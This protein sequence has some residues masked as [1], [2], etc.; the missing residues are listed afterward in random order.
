MS[1]GEEGN[2]KC[3]SMKNNGI[4]L[5]LRWC[6]KPGKMCYSET[7]I[8]KRDKLPEGFPKRPSQWLG[9]DFGENKYAPRT[10]RGRRTPLYKKEFA[11][12]SLPL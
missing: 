5:A 4:I 10:N 11:V 6:P 8:E 7:R 12:K 9:F 2:L 1:I 3:K